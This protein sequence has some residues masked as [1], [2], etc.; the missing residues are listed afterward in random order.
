MNNVSNNGFNFIDLFAGCGGLSEGFYM[1]GFHALAHV[2]I[3]STACK[4][5]RT[6]MNHYGYTTA[7]EAVLRWILHVMMLLNVSKSL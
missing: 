2:E 7:E 3:Y 5:L 1:Q 6:R 4:T